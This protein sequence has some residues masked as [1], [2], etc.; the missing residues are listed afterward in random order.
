MATTKINIT[1]I[2]DFEQE[3]EKI[4]DKKIEEKFDEWMKEYLAK[5][6]LT[7]QDLEKINK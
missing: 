7:I 3:V 5:Y 4:I 2:K 6:N 1:K